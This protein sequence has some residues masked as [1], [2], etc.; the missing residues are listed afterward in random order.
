VL[1]NFGFGGRVLLESH[2]CALAWWVIQ[3]MERRL[4][5]AWLLYIW[6]LV[7]LSILHA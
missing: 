5:R 2:G 3:V 4:R 1:D 7:V 6:L